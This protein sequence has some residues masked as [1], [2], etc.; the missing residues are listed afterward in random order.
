MSNVR[1]KKRTA[2]LLFLFFALVLGTLLYTNSRTTPRSTFLMEGKNKLAV[3]GEVT[4]VSNN[5]SLIYCIQDLLLEAQEENLRVKNIN[6]SVVWSQKLPGKIVKLTAAGENIIIVDNKN[7]INYY[8]LKGK[9]L[10]TYKPDYEIIDIFTEDNGSFLVEYKGMTGS[11]AEVFTQKGT[12]IGSIAV[13]NSHVLS[14]STG[15][16]AFSI[17]ILDTSAE[18]VKTKII[19]YNFKGDILWAQNFEDEIISKLNYNNN[20]KLL[21]LGENIIYIYKNDGSIQGDTVIEGKIRNIAMSDYITASIILDKGKQYIVAYDSNMREQSR[22]EINGSPSGIYPMKN[23]FILYYNDELLVITVKGELIT[24]YK[25]NTDI[26]SA[27]MTSD[28]KI[29]IV[30]NRKLQ[31]LDVLH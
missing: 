16:N 26:S 19:T 21:A 8:T 4:A 13:E 20:N 24:R 3:I 31:Q 27:Y 15:A 9:L 22:T 12:K 25:S 18:E 6:G 10:W 7:N 5:S 28:N 1:L 2:L 29:Y 17:S 30:S 14:F 11:H 23:R